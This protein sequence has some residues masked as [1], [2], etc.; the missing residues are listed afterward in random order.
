VIVSAHA[1]GYKVHRFRPGEG[2]GFLSTIKIHSMPSFGGDVK[3][4]VPCYTI[5]QHVKNPFKV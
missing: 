2:D 4:E 3:T 1:I 5:L